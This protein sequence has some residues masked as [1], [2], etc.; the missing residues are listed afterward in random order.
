MN[1]S[2]YYDQIIDL[3]GKTVDDALQELDALIC[4]SPAKR[5]KI[6]HGHGTGRLKKAVRDFVSS[7]E[8]VSQIQLGEDLMTSGSSGTL[9]IEVYFFPYT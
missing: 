9:I 1:S 5:I 7:H 2:Q 4:R 3:H 8:L 6:I